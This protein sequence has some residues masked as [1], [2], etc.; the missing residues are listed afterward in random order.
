[1]STAR[2]LGRTTASTGAVEELTA[3]AANAF[4]LPRTINDQTGTTYTLQASDFNKL[5]RCANGSAIALTI[6][7][8]LSETDWPVGG[9]CDLKQHG[10][11][12]VTVGVSGSAT[13]NGT[14]TKTRIQGSGAT[15]FREA[16]NT[17]WL[18]GDIL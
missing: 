5:V 13:V 1:M 9:S 6:P 2:L 8:N 4:L 17:Y 18:A 12:R 11:G 14:G 16:T 10:A 7:E 15:I 3:A